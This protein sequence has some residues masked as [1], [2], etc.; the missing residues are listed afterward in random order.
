[1][2]GRMT[3]VFCAVWSKDPN[4]HALIKQH[5]SNLLAQTKPVD[6]VYVFDDGD[7]PPEGL[8]ARTI[9]VGSPLGIYEAWNVALS[10][11]RT[12]FV[13]NLNL[14]DRLAPDAVERL[15]HEMLASKGNLIGGDWN[16]CFS[17]EETDAVRPVHLATDIPFLPYW[18]P[19]PFA[20]TRLG[21]GTG[22][23]GTYG[24]ATMWRLD[25]HIAHPRYPYRT[26]NNTPIKSVADAVW[27]GMLVQHNAERVLR[28]PAIIGNYYS[29]PSDQAEFRL[30][31]ETKLVSTQPI[32]LV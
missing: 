1:M 5:Q 23:R 18:P 10:M 7:L 21:S 29:H 6:I 17:Q 11:C 31:D 2:T 4:R 16:I 25:C 22:E 15:E 27:W 3:T 26:V 19:K 20:P 14:D 24:P 12:E 30:G 13:M 8:V 32:S 28:Y 9:S